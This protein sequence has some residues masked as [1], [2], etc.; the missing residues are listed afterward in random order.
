RKTPAHADADCSRDL[1]RRARR[2]KPFADDAPPRIEPALADR[3][4]RRNVRVD[5]DPTEPDR[6]IR[7]DPAEVAEEALHVSEQT[8]RIEIVT[9]GLAGVA[10]RR[11]ARERDRG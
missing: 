1:G 2:L 7:L 8:L 6:C 10:E 5:R 9:Y 4:S 11:V 3:R